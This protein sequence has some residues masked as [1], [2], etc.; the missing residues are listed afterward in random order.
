MQFH[1][2]TAETAHLLA[3]STV[4]DNPV[5]PAQ[6]AAF[7]ADPGHLMVFVTGDE[8][9]IGFATGTVL[10][11]P[12]KPPA[13]FLNEVDVAP[14]HQRQ[15]IGVQLCSRLMDRARAAGCKGI[16]LATEADNAPARA[17]YRKLNARE[18]TGIVVYDWDGAMDG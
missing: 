5:D 17:L 10:L 2:L 15:G 4:F 14:D 18:T 3:G 13:F 12:D 16:W 11:H 1:D 8:T 7:V 6:L 9:V